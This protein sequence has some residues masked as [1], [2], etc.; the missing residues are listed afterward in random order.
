M[1]IKIAFIGAGSLTFTRALF[2]DI[3]TVPV[4]FII[5]RGGIILVLEWPGGGVGRRLSGKVQTVQE[6]L[7]TSKSSL[8]IVESPS[9][10]EGIQF[11][12][13][14]VEPG[15]TRAGEHGPGDG[16]SCSK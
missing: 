2:R 6:V 11:M 8:T 5:R 3:L 10:A 16:R 13:F 14:Q 12:D 1:A 7:D 15:C 4:A 9:F